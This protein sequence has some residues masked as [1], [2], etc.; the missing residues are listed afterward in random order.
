MKWCSLWRR[1]GNQPIAITQRK[2]V[3]VIID[4]KEIPVILKFKKDGSPYLEPKDQGGCL[5]E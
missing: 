4:K 3:I 5:N 1:I 2:D